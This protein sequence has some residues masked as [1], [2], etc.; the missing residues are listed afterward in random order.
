MNTPRQNNESPRATSENAGM[1]SAPD[2]AADVAARGTA[3]ALSTGTSLRDPGGTDPA[4]GRGKPGNQG[5]AEDRLHQ[6]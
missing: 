3:T 4:G 5:S 2:G 1:G 6:H